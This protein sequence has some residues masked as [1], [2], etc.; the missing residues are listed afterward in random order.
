MRSDPPP[1]FPRREDHA[2]GGFVSDHSYQT[3]GGKCRAAPDHGD[4]AT[5]AKSRLLSLL[6]LIF[7]KISAFFSKTA[8]FYAFFARFPALFC[9]CSCWPSALH[10]QIYRQSVRPLSARLNFKQTADE[11]CNDEP[12]LYAM[13]VL[14]YNPVFATNRRG[15]Q[16]TQD[17]LNFPCCFCLMSKWLLIVI[18]LQLLA[19]TRQQSP[20][21]RRLLWFNPALRGWRRVQ[22]IVG[23]SGCSGYATI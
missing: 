4:D 13:V 11:P 1:R 16:S 7:G 21:G 5:D 22:R 20:V 18:C 12:C 23:L 10:Y 2:G 15:Q 3:S 14:R 8:S 19:E 6:L 17:I 9:S